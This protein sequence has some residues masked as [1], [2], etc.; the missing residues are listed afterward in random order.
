MH[1]NIKR[2]EILIQTDAG[3]PYP[4]LFPV[5]GDELSFERGDILEKLVMKFYGKLSFR[6]NRK[7]ILILT[8]K[9]FFILKNFMEKMPN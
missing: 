5:I 1:W 3:R 4:P 6:L 7:K 9:N 8:M 2:N